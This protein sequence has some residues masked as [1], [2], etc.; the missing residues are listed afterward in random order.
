MERECKTHGLTA[1]VKRK[2]GKYTTWRCRQC[3]VD[4]V[5]KRRRKVKRQLIEA[6]GGCCQLCGY[7]RCDAALQFHHKDPT[8]KGFT[9][10]GKQFIALEKAL[11]EIKKC[12]LLCANCHAEVE[13]GASTLPAP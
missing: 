7:D 3:A 11:E 6:A 13:T 10:S 4:A 9:I 12:V 1:Y 2:N 5:T 8:Q